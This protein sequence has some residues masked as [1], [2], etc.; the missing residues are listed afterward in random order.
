[1]IK[2]LLRKFC[3]IISVLISFIPLLHSQ[4]VY[5]PL[6]EDVYNFLRRLS[7]KGI[8]EFDDQ[9]RPVSRIYIAER[10]YLAK[11]A[12][13]YPMLT[14]FEKEELKY[15][16][17]DYY[18]E[19][20]FI[21]KR[22][23]INRYDSGD[24]LRYFNYD[25]GD[26]W[27]MFSYGSEGF[28]INADLIFGGEIGSVKDE[29]QTHF[30]NGFYSYGY[31]YDILGFSFDFRDNTENGNTIDKTKSFSP[32]T[33]V[34]ART[35]MNYYN[36]P[37]DK[38]EYSEA[39]M[40]LATDWSWGSIAGGK[41]FLEWGYGD[42]GLLVLSQKAPSFPL[43]RLDIKPV[44]WLSF[45]YFHAWL[46]SDVIDT[47][48]LYTTANGDHRFLFREKYLASHTL[49]IKPT[50]GLD[51][52]IGESIIYADRLEYLYLIPITFFRLA[53]HYLS[54]QANS[55]GGNAQFF[56]SV[57]SKGHIKNTHLYGTLLID[58]LTLNGL[59]KSEYQRNQI[60]FSLGSSVT[61]LPIDNLTLKLEYTK[62]YPYAYQHYISTTTY[63]SAS[64]V[65]GH[66]MN[67]NADQVFA[68]VNYRFLRGLDALV[69]TRYIRQGERANPTKQ[70][71]QPQPP[72]LSGL[73]TNHTYIG[74]QVKYEIL[75]D[76]FMKA[77]FQYMN[78]SKQQEDLSFVDDDNQ[79][80]HFDVY[81][82]L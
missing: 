39:K 81:Y 44:D 21:D 24:Q 16:I 57:S 5:E 3:L 59:F 67:N 15:F 66:W 45:N 61:D 77:W 41:D 31:I 51:V 29:K 11:M 30:W 50:R 79:E 47:T 56:F 13:S 74:A 53:D 34:N 23:G 35:S 80:F 82:G 75:H 14:S 40:I 69:W 71:D 37:S 26:R 48:S 60:G 65:L 46:S 62:I 8:I 72:F 78:T 6:Y 18:H 63:E 20:S 52:S 38:M 58:E 25:Y 1:M 2:L 27:R 4:V 55:A 70:F 54:R 10:L 22:N 76:L 12:F 17:K 68:S 33:G 49:T 19:M 7:Q 36:Y 9:I 42:N 32:E 43:V 64:Y 73:R 28:K